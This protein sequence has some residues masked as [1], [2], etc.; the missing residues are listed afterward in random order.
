MK[1]WLAVFAVSLLVLVGLAAGP[2]GTISF[3]LTFLSARY[4]LSAREFGFER[5]RAMLGI[6]LSPPLWQRSNW[7]WLETVLDDETTFWKACSIAAGLTALSLM[8]SPLHVGIFAVVIASCYVLDIACASAPTA[9]L[10]ASADRGG[11]VSTFAKPTVVRVIAPPGPTAAK[12]VK[13]P[14]LVQPAA[15]ASPPP[16][17]APAPAARA[18]PVS[19][20]AAPPAAPKLS[21]VAPP[22]PQ[23]PVTPAK[24]EAKT[25]AAPAAN[26]GSK[27]RPEHQLDETPRR[28]P[29]KQPTQQISLRQQQQRQS[30]HQKPQPKR[31]TRKQPRQASRR[32]PKPAQQQAQLPGSGR[33]DQPSKQ[34]PLRKPTPRRP[35]LSAGRPARQQPRLATHRPGKKLHRRK[36]D[37]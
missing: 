17:A 30:A 34:R 16:V 6:A 20:S 5:A 29:P 22:Q 9:R 32:K 35:P 25:P 19:A 12:P 21:A 24:V 3:L 26:A 4:L 23:P 18:A 2:F 28:P 15:A 10:P 7:Q 14:T 1:N 8:L 27:P 37:Q 36:T 13:K 11:N 31:P 33:P